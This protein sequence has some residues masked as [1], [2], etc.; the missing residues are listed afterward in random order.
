CSRERSSPT[1]AARCSIGPASHLLPRPWRKYRTPWRRSARGRVRCRA[2]S[3]YA[4][5]V[6]PPFGLLLTRDPPPR[7]LGALVAVAAVALCTLIIYP[8]KHVAPVVSL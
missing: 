1:L 5:A 7:R 4:E 8:L 2:S 6:S 3:P